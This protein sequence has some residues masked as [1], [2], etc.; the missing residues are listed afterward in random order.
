[1][2]LFVKLLLFHLAAMGISV[3]LGWYVAP[4]WFL[5]AVVLGVNLIQSAFSGVCPVTSL[6]KAVEEEKSTPPPA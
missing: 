4:L 2:K 3:A 6:F 1:M 5:I